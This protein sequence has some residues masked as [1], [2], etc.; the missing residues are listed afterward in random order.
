MTE[1]SVVNQLGLATPLLR[2]SQLGVW[3][4]CQVGCEEV[5]LDLY[6]GEV[7]AIVGESGSGKSTL[8]RCVSGRQRPDR[9]HVWLHQDGQ[10][11]DLHGIA[12]AD[13]VRLLRRQVGFVAQN[14]RDGLRM[15]ISAGGNL[16][17]PL[18]ANGE[19]HYGDVREAAL[20]WMERVELDLARIDEPPSHFSGGMQQRLQIARSLVNRPQLVCMDEPTGGLDVSVQ[21]RLLD[22]LRRLV[23]ELQLSVV[24]VT[25]DLG[26]ARLLAERMI[27]M[28]HGRVIEAGLTDQVLDDPQHPYTQL[29]A[30]SVI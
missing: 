6:A 13:R 23:E 3:Y 18:L 11:V 29:L 17:E 5:S 8:L 20:Q 26:V 27:V 22:L 15:R 30:S 1:E 21:A 14:P 4:G 16:G 2:V 7:L 25:H 10:E 24:I 19:R 12:E 28:Q 9:G